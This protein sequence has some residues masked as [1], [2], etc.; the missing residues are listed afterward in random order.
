[1]QSTWM[2]ALAGLGAIVA[3]VGSLLTWGSA[4]VPV[5]G[6]VT[7]SGF[8]A[9]REGA[10]TLGLSLAL[11][12]LLV[13]PLRAS[14]RWPGGLAL[15]VALLA[16]AVLDAAQLQGRKALVEDW[17]FGLVDMSVGVGLV[18]VF[19]GVGLSLAATLAAAVLERRALVHRSAVER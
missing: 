8:D 15:G 12:V 10:I 19:A 11:L 18:L 4:E 1:M 13:L 14:L 17:G 5:I 2:R 9:H 7:L 16:V 6:S 3:V